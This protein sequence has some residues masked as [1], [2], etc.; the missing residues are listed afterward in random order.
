MRILVQRVKK[1][2]VQ[3]EAKE[4]AAIQHGLLL[5]VAVGEG[6]DSK[7]IEHMVNKVLNLRIFPDDSG[8]MNLSIRQ[9][10]GEILSVPQFTLYADTSGGNRPGFE[11]S[12]Q[13][14][15]ARKLWQDFNSVLISNGLI[16]KTGNFGAEMQVNLINDG[17]VTIWLDSKA[18]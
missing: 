7:D 11:Q 3:V 18:K 13:P 9:V 5:F 4:I 2:S 12:A 17:P 10:S 15:I 8:K 14:I 6:D 16:V 1:A